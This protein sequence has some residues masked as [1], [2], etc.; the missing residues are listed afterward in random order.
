MRFVLWAGVV[1]AVSCVKQPGECA[2]QTCTAQQFCNPETL[3]CE[4]DRP[5]RVDF[6]V[7]TDFVTSRSIAVRGTA[8]DDLRVERLEWRLDDGPWTHATHT[9]GTF[10][11]EVALPALDQ[12]SV[13]IAVR[14]FDALTHTERVKTMPVDNLVDLEVL[15]P[16][17]GSHHNRPI[18][19]RVR[20]PLDIVTLSAQVLGDALVTVPLGGPEAQVLVPIPSGDFTAQSLVVTGVDS[21]GNERAETVQL[22]TDTV[23]PRASLQAPALDAR[24]NAAD[25]AQNDAVQLTWIAVDQDPRLTMRVGSVDTGGLATTFVPTREDDDGVEYHRTIEVSD[26]AGNGTTLTAR[27]SVDRVA[28]RVSTWLPAHDARNVEDTATVLTFSEPV[29]ASDAGVPAF[30]FLNGTMP[31]SATWNSSRTTFTAPIDADYEVVHLTTSQLADA[32]GNP[33][34]TTVRRFHTAMHPL[35]PGVHVLVSSN[36]ANFANSSDGDGVL[37]LLWRHNTSNQAT[38]LYVGGPPDAGSRSEE[39]M[40]FTSWHEVDDS[41]L[42]ATPTFGA[43]LSQTSGFL[44]AWPSGSDTVNIAP[45]VVISA[46]PLAGEVGASGVGLVR[47]TEYV[48]GAFSISVSLNPD[49]PRAIT[50]SSTAWSLYRGNKQSRYSC[51]TP[52]VGAPHCDVHQHALPVTLS[53]QTVR[54]TST[55]SGDCELLSHDGNG[56]QLI[57][58]PR[59]ACETTAAGCPTYDGGAVDAGVHAGRFGVGRYRWNGEDALLYTVITQTGEDFT[60]R[61]FKTS[62]CSMTGAVELPDVTFESINNDP[63]VVVPVQLGGK[64]ALLQLYFNTLQL[65]TF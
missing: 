34:T 12:Q 38:L 47:A 51:V 21:R 60:V 35:A 53:D 5:P 23:A 18:E 55:W 13:S 4:E 30:T 2:G 63:G 24:F 39:H 57:F 25:L 45:A 31:P 64:V 22:F 43:G 16:V 29:F 17:H 54:A 8:K 58:A 33:L 32:F 26:R 11:F 65:R 41:T 28:P 10:S 42:R 7:P 46:P 37:S 1:L 36:V 61:T 49:S 40:M 50:Q 62:T 9:E 52:A 6:T 48:R 44:R 20:V 15:T 14:A 59:P 27:F 56:G 3:H 19:L